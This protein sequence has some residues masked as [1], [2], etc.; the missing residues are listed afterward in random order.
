MTVARSRHRLT[1][2]RKPGSPLQGSLSGRFSAWLRN[3]G[4]QSTLSSACRACNLIFR[5]SRDEAALVYSTGDD[6]VAT[7]DRGKRYLT[8]ESLV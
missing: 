1:R 5:A 6:H 4:Y 3:G 7:N 8:A 2:M